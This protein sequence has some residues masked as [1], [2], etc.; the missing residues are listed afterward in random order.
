LERE[1]PGI[2]V[3]DVSSS[4]PYNE[5][6]KLLQLLREQKNLLQPQK[7]SVILYLDPK[8]PVSR[9]QTE[10]SGLFQILL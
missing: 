5:Y 4:T 3:L 2:I 9:E 8:K 10:K 1:D 7:I 6:E